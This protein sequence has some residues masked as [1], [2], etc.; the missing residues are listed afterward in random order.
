[1]KKLILILGLCV[2]SILS[3]QTKAETIQWLNQKFKEGTTELIVSRCDISII[4]NKEIGEAFNLSHLY[5]EL[6]LRS[7][8]FLAG[9]V[10]S[11]GIETCGEYD[12]VINVYFKNSSTILFKY[13][14]D[15]EG[16]FTSK[17]ESTTDRMRLV[18]KCG[19][20][21]AERIKRGLIHL[22]NIS[23]AELINEDLF[24]D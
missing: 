23:G 14:V 20:K 6:E 11:V 7:T 1:M 18:I 4:E 22:F 8:V 24:N 16:N 19:Y 2:S 15:S 9:Q 13:C 21:R 3:A 5:P 12:C 10:S 17:K